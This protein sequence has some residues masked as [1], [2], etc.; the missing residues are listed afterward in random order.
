MSFYAISTLTAKLSIP[1]PCHNFYPLFYPLFILL[2]LSLVSTPFQLLVCA[3]WLL[4]FILILISYAICLCLFLML[5][6]CAWLGWPLSITYHILECII[7]CFVSLRYPSG[8]DCKHPS[9]TCL[10]GL[11]FFDD[12][13]RG[14][15]GMTMVILVWLGLNW[16]LQKFSLFWLHCFGTNLCFPFMSIW[17]FG[18]SSLKMGNLLNPSLYNVRFWWEQTQ[19]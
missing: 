8:S 13:K 1:S 2:F 19:M 3:I 7:D 11:T 15:I 17:S 14:K 6:V 12:V 18:L 9:L 4:W 16:F 5:F 10:L